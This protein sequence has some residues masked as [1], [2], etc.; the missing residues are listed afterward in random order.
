MQVLTNTPVPLH[1]SND[2]LQQL[3]P[4]V[5]LP[6][7]QTHA[8]VCPRDVR[9]PQKRDELRSEL[10]ALGWA[11]FVRLVNQGKKPERFPTVSSG[12]LARVVPERRPP[13]PGLVALVQNPDQKK[14]A[15]GTGLLYSSGQRPHGGQ[16]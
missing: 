15:A 1:S 12:P 4:A 8:A 16:P 2:D 7:L 9:C 3:F 11:W 10:F 13:A 5:V 14:R 6:R